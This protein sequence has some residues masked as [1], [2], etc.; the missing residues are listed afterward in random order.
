MMGGYDEPFRD[1]VARDRLLGAKTVA[2][3]RRFRQLFLRLKLSV[4]NSWA[5]SFAKTSDGL[6]FI[7]R[8]TKVP[9]TWFA[10]GYGG[11]GITFSV[12]AAQLIR[13]QILH[14]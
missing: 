14:H 2:L 9:H 12:L 13:N 10:L 11:N 1:P 6:P 3:K 8:H 5:G 4:A 7:G